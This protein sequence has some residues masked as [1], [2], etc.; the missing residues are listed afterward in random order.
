MFLL[1]ILYVIT[2]QQLEVEIKVQSPYIIVPENG[3][4]SRLASMC[5]VQQGQVYSLLLTF[6]ILLFCPPLLSITTMATSPYP[7]HLPPCFS[8]HHLLVVD[9]GQLSFTGST[10]DPKTLM[11][12]AKSHNHAFFPNLDHHH[13][14]CSNF[15]I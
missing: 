9:L 10:K 11:K 1:E 3:F 2:S 14:V 15:I 12:V 8:D 7:P 4:Y 13:S 5:S 6:P